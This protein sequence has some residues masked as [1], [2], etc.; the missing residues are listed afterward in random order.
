[1]Q[2]S[3]TTLD[4]CRRE[5]RISMT[6][7]DLRPHF[8]TA[9]QKAQSGISLPGFRKGKVPVS[10]VKQKFGREIEAEALESIADD[11][12]RRYTSEESLR[13]VGHPVLTDILKSSDGVTFT[14]SFE[15]LPDFSLGDYRGLD[16]QRLVRVAG[17]KDV[18]AEIDRICLNAATFPPAEEV[19]DSMHVVAITLH[20]LDRDTGLPVLGAESKEQRVFLDDDNIDLHL[21]NSIQGLKIGDSFQY[22][23]EA[24]DEN[25]RPPTYRVTI[26]DI[27]KVVP[28]E[29]NNELVESVSSGKFHTTEELRN[30]IE[31]QIN[32]YIR[33]ASRDSLE[34][35]LVD[36]LVK[37]HTFDVPGSLVHAVIHQLFD[38][39][40]KRNEGMP[41]LDKLTAH[42]LEH[43]FQPDAERIVRWELIRDEIVKA[44][45]IEISDDDVARAAG[46]FGVSE[47]QVR[48]ILRQNREF[49]DQ[50]LAEKVVQ[51]LIDYAI[52]TDV[53][54]DS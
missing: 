51:T 31:R 52:I 20:E 43:E 5:V 32:E 50:L 26:A 10:I 15:I 16:I 19:T 46:R 12:F 37:N 42:E 44:E 23:A 9:Y 24:Q 4:G 11:E 3:L 33:Q 6:H 30:D 8:D 17:E 22:I 27:N 21:R 2:R 14:V 29:F 38:D 25:T 7:L 34:N 18:Q 45:S 28:A 53:N 13:V 54:V 48:M 40:K 1:M 47:D 36:Q 35:Q 39:F 41:G 49:K